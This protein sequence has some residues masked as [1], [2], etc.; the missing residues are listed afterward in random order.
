MRSL[1][2]FN[3]EY[4]E[5]FPGLW[6][7][8]QLKYFLLNSK[9]K[10]SYYLPMTPLEHICYK[11]SPNL[12]STSMAYK[13]LTQL[14]PID[15]H[16]HKKKW[17][18]DLG[19]KL[20]DAQWEKACILAHK[21]S[22]STKAQ[23][24]SYK[25]LIQWH[26]TPQ[27]ARRWFPTTSDTCWRCGTETGSFMHIW[28]TCLPIQ[29]YWGK[30]IRWIKYITET[31]I[32][33]NAAACLIHVNTYTLSKYKKSLTRHLLNAAKTLIPLHWKS[34]HTPG[35]KD[36]FDKVQYTYKMEE[37]LV[38]KKENNTNFNKMWQPWYLFTLSDEF[39]TA[40]IPN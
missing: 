24:I 3:E 16:N 28:W 30:I 36:W 34:T 29:E 7:Y 22:L 26:V 6:F 2:S 15:S 12:K 1:E 38:M 11:R 13:W 25:I 8:M 5:S 37:I 31:K 35:V 18:I 10:A 4:G 32:N 17:E 19:I 9:N 33:L 39:K 40:T 21:C 23:E 14:I 27:K 20:S